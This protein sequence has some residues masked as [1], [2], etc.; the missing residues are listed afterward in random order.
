MHQN[1]VQ[2]DG[3][4]RDSDNWQK[5][6]PMSAYMKSAFRHFIDWWT[7]YRRGTP[8]KDAALAL[9]FNVMGFLHEQVSSSTPLTNDI[10]W[11]GAAEYRKLKKKGLIIDGPAA[12]T[13]DAL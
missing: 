8:N 12:K 10:V 2:A 7:S 3:N 4:L 6:I 9:L 11:I 1:R 5:G 13:D